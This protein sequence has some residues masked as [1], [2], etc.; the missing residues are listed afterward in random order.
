[1]G[2]CGHGE[3]VTDAEP[4][5]RFLR[6]PELFTEVHDGYVTV[7]YRCVVSRFGAQAEDVAAALSQAV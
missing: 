7:I 3:R 6:E 4:A 5:A 1:V 2:Y